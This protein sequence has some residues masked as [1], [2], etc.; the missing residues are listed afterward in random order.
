M[1][2]QRVITA[3]VI[4]AVLSVL[5]LWAPPAMVLFVLAATVCAGA[6]EWALFPRLRAMAARIAYALL[7]L[8][9]AIAAWLL[10]RDD[11]AQLQQLLWI[12]LAWWVLAFLWIVLAPAVQNRLTAALGGFLVMAPA[13]VALMQLYRQ[14]NGPQLVLFLLILV[15]AADVGAFFAG[16]HFGRMK[17]APRV[18]PNKTW[19]G[20]IGGMVVSSAVAV[21]GVWWFARPPLA[22]I[23]LCLGVVLVSIVGDLTESMFKRYAGLKDSGSLFP[24]HGGVLDRFDS[25]FAAAPTF[26]LGL[27]WLESA[28]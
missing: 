8:S 12:S 6:W 21:A 17:L 18:S 20:L 19:E 11:P 9:A 4:G 10:T 28:T 2:Q 3:A 22:F 1:L 5:L 7:V 15:W 26:L 24:G 27:H 14:P 16:R 13:S 23:S 25:V